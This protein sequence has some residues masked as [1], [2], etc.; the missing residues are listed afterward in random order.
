[1][2][3]RDWLIWFYLITKSVTTL[4]GGQCIMSK[5][6]LFIRLSSGRWIPTSAMWRKCFASFSPSSANCPRRSCGPPPCASQRWSSTRSSL[7]TSCRPRTRQPR[8]EF[9]CRKWF[10]VAD[11][12]PVSTSRWPFFIKLFYECSLWQF[13]ILC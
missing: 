9:C 7:D 1:M 3:I 2:S 8:P 10:G 6:F 12:K 4:S 11:N 5:Y 13:A